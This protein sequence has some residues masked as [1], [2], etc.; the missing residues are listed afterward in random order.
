[1]DIQQEL[2]RSIGHGP[3]LPTP[4][5]RL[6]AGR[7]AL[8]RRRITVGGAAAVVAAL[9]VTPLA[10]AAGGGDHASDPGPAGPAPVTTSAPEPEPTD[11]ATE[12]E[13]RW[14]E[15]ESIRL[16][17][18]GR[19]RRSGPVSRSSTASTAI[20]AARA[21]STAWPWRSAG[22]ARSTGSR[23]SGTASPAAGPERHRGQRRLGRLPGPGRPR[24]RQSTRPSGRIRATATPT[25]SSPV[26]TA[27]SARH[28]VRPSCSRA[29]PRGCRRTSRRPVTPPVLP[30]SR[31][32]GSATSSSPAPGDL[33]VVPSPPATGTPS[34]SC[35]RGRASATTPGGAALTSARDTEFTAYVAA[36]Q[37][38]LRRVA[39]AVC[40][41]WHRAED[42][43]QTALTKLYVAWPRLHHDGRED[44]YVRQIIVRTNI[45]DTRDRG[46]VASDPASTATTPP[47]VSCCRPRNASALLDALLSCPRCSARS[48]C[49]GTGSGSRSRRLRPTSRSPPAR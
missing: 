28:R 12:Q 46:G 27:R 25:W 9:M 15:W 20:C 36:R 40:G 22:T 16:P 26:V 31:R 17:A 39:Y 6:A 1:M 30:T 33:V 3:T 4:E 35:S 19:A 48:S 38:H 44:G 23:P 29:P 10:I 2:E 49:S 18:D 42:V 14:R 13:P 43:L 5:Q 24:R 37:A 21:G 47:H 45:D 34:T 41:D 32:A 11:E 7:W 8:R